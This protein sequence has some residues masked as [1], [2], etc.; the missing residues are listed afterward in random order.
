M[1]MQVQKPR[2]SVAAEPAKPDV[3]LGTVERVEEIL[4]NAQGPVSKNYLHQQLVARQAGTTPARL[5][6][7]LQYLNSHRM[8]VEGSKGIQW[9]H[10]TSASLAIARTNGRRL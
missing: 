9:T 2:P 7:V 4:Q 8:I 5:N 1:Q 6:R 10:N 3:L